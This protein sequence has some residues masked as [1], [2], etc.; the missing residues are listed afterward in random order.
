MKCAFVA[1]VVVVEL[2]SVLRVVN[3]VFVGSDACDCA[4][5][6]ALNKVRHHCA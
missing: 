3:G 2:R 6:L 4:F 1:H 5:H